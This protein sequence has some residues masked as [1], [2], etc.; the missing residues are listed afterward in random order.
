MQPLEGKAVIVTGAGGGIGADHARLA[1]RLGAAVV[2]CD[3][4]ET[5]AA[6]IAAEITGSGGMARA[7]TGDITDPA[8]PDALVAASFETFGTLSG[9]INNAGV[10][11]PDKIESMRREDLMKTLEVNVLGTATCAQAAIMAWRARG[12]GG[13]IVNTASG[14]HAGDV[15]LGAYA[16]SKGAVASLTYSWAMELRGSPIR[17]N[18]I[19]P[20]AM[21]PMAQRNL[22][23]LAEQS[24]AR[25]VSYASLP[26]PATN[27]PVACYLLSDAAAGIHGQ[28]VRIAG[29]ELSFVT[30]PMIA[31][32]V[33]RGAWS[34]EAV[35][36]AFAETLG[37]A[38]KA[39]GLTF[40]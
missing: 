31:A 18:A 22:D 1:A 34:F 33:L 19:S 4:D 16:A 38:Q 5:G 15:S 11:L 21:T 6:A 10:L 8:V 27:A 14:S 30:H 2:V 40:A 9:L 28:I 17:M 39:L 32:P 29:D 37:N 7:F 3:L 24:A 25:E 20:L 13:S 23:L 36:R 12:M 35:E 26:D